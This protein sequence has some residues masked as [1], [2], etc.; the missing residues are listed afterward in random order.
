MSGLRLRIDLDAFA[1]NLEVVRARVGPA[2]LMLVV[3]DDAYG[4][5]IQRIVGEGPGRGRPLVRR[6]RSAAKR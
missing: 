2:Q 1:A 5:G 6:L 4:H 3:K